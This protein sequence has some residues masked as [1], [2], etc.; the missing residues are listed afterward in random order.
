MTLRCGINVPPPAAAPN[1]CALS[2]CSSWLNANASAASPPDP[3]FDPQLDMAPLFHGFGFGSVD[4]N[5]DMPP[6]FWP[7]ADP[8]PD[9]NPAYALSSLTSGAITPPPPIALHPPL[10]WQMPLSASCSTPAASAAA[11]FSCSSA[12]ASS[13]ASAAAALSPALASGVPAVGVTSTQTL[14]RYAIPRAPSPPPAFIWKRELI[15]SLLP[16]PEPLCAPT[17]TAAPRAFERPTALEPDAAAASY[18]VRLVGDARASWSPDACPVH[19]VPPIAGEFTS[20]LLD[21]TWPNA[22]PLPPP[23][24]VLTQTTFAAACSA[25]SL[26]PPAAAAAGVRVTQLPA[27]APTSIAPQ[28]SQQPTQQ[29]PISR[30]SST[31]ESL[32]R[33]A[34]PP[35]NASSARTIQ[36]APLVSSAAAR[37]APGQSIERAFSA[38]SSAGVFATSSLLAASLIEPLTP[39][40]LQS[41]AQRLHQ[42]QQLQLPAVELQVED[43]IAKIEP[44]ELAAFLQ[45]CSAPAA[46][47]ASDLSTTTRPL[48]GLRSVSTCQ[49]PGQPVILRRLLQPNSVSTSA[50]A[51]HNSA[52]ATRTPPEA[53]LPPPPPPPHSSP[54]HMAQTSAAYLQLSPTRMDTSAP[55]PASMSPLTARLLMARSA[56]PQTPAEQTGA[57]ATSLSQLLAGDAPSGRFAPPPTDAPPQPQPQHPVVIKCEFKTNVASTPAEA[58]VK[59][60]PHFQFDYELLRGAGDALEN[61]VDVDTNVRSSRTRLMSE[62]T[63]V[64]R[65]DKSDL[66]LQL[67]AV[68]ALHSRSPSASNSSDAGESVSV[69]E[70]LSSDTRHSSSDTEPLSPETAAAL[71]L[72]NVGHEDRKP[73]PRRERSSTTSAAVSSSESAALNACDLTS[74]NRAVQTHKQREMHSGCS[75]YK[76]T[77]KHRQ[78]QSSTSP[79][80]VHVGLHDDEPPLVRVAACKIARP[81]AAAVEPATPS[82]EQRREYICDFPGE[83]DAMRCNALRFF[84]EKLLA[85]QSNGFCKREV[86]D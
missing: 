3:M 84:F 6:P 23:A 62:K 47:L 7:L 79:D 26:P 12:A 80:G 74:V 20:Q 39:L 66:Q 56:A 58:D 27:A 21:F 36:Q 86:L 53:L 71:C 37:I 40:P 59:P 57:A 45:K 82:S 18:A 72:D 50:S 54:A 69:N 83:C 63:L 61:A 1:A 19:P 73:T 2:T 13:S 34:S 75:T 67:V 28:L 70:Q 55:T 8:E 33:S 42:Q 52:R 15:G 9:L 60:E 5:V 77:R 78:S 68:G 14:E 30:K 49:Q 32:L 44:D 31:L 43:P 85:S 38:P 51:G 41:P 48:I 17:P 24:S 16:S 65:A 35:P 29:K 76:Y 81:A 25:A 10:A 4:D 64:A 22:T 11:F 46:P